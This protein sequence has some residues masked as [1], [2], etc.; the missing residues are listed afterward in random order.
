MLIIRC[1]EK[2]TLYEVESCRLLI[3]NIVS[4]FCFMFSVWQE[5]LIKILIMI[6]Y[7][8]YI[9]R[10]SYNTNKKGPKER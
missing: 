1:G 5:I 10:V 2:I 3:L 4:A 7:N 6:L 9:D 8:K